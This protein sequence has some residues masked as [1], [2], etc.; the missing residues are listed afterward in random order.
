MTRGPIRTPARS[1][2]GP[3]GRGVGVGVASG[4]EKP[5]E[6]CAMPATGSNAPAIASMLDAMVSR[7]RCRS[8]NK[9]GFKR[10]F[11]RMMRI[12]VG[13]LDIT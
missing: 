1:S 2:A 5:G 13:F 4:K 8:G 11:A 3:W 6:L 7:I 10:F 12:G 9:I